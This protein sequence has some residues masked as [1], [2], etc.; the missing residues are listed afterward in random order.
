MLFLCGISDTIAFSDKSLV[1]MLADAPEAGKVIMAVK[2]IVIVS[3]SMKIGVP[4]DFT[5]LQLDCLKLIGAVL[6]TTV[7]CA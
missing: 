1:L 5:R 2:D 7:L 4:P 6:D 3:A